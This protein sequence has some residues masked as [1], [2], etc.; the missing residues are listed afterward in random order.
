M[1]ERVAKAILETMTEHEADKIIVNAVGE[2]YR[3][4]YKLRELKEYQ[5][6]YDAMNSLLNMLMKDMEFIR[7]TYKIK[8]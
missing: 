5:E 8:I 3:G 1:I 7:D 6:E 4:Y 2:L